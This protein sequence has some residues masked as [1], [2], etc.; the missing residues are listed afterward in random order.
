MEELST[1]QILDNI[2]NSNQLFNKKEEIISKL[3]DENMTTEYHNAYDILRNFLETELKATFDDMEIVDNVL[4]IFHSEIIKIIAKVKE[5][6][7]VL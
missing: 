5:I 1:Q 2:T 7:V 3:I 6:K 4:A